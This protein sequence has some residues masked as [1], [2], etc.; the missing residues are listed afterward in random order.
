MSEAVPMSSPFHVSDGAQPVS[1]AVQERW[2][3]SLS[4]SSAGTFSYSA[5]ALCHKSSS[6]TGIPCLLAQINCLQGKLFKMCLFSIMYK[7]QIVGKRMFLPQCN[8]EYPILPFS[9]K[10]NN[11]SLSAASSRTDLRLSEIIILIAVPHI[12]QD[13]NHGGCWNFL[14]S[15]CSST[16][17]NTKIQRNRQKSSI[18]W[19]HCLVVAFPFPVGI[20]SFSLLHNIWFS[21]QPEF[22][23]WLGNKHT[24]RKVCLVCFTRVFACYFFSLTAKDGTAGSLMWL[25]IWMSKFGKMGSTWDACLVSV[26]CKGFMPVWMGTHIRFI[27]Q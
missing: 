14:P 24:Y 16:L 23:R 22:P 9:S 8:I 18:I 12:L 11:L 27:C 25:L 1:G 26:F 21:G 2:L 13:P 6:V 10:K 15:F 4:V 19:V 5:P 3:S 7:K 20:H 17:K